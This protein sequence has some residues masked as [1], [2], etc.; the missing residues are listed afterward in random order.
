MLILVGLKSLLIRE[1][2]EIENFLEVLILEE[3]KRDCPEILILRGLWGN[4]SNDLRANMRKDSIC[5]Q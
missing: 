2:Q 3:L 1:M 4:N 5:I